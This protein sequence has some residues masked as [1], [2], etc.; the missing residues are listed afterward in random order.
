MREALSKAG[1]IKNGLRITS[2]FSSLHRIQNTVV[3]GVAFEK[4]QSH[5]FLSGPTRNL[6]QP[7]LNMI[8]IF[9]PIDPSPNSPSLVRANNMVM[10][11][12]A[13]WL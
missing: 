12:H 3:V 10:A 2:E 5:Y 7:H 8:C 6:A 1:D 11:W 9:S 13:S 4:A